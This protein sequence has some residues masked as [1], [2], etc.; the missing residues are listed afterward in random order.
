MTICFKVYCSSNQ[1]TKCYQLFMLMVCSYF[2]LT[3]HLIL[4]FRTEI[5]F[6]S[7]Q[8]N[9]LLDPTPHFPLSHYTQYTVHCLS[10]GF[11]WTMRKTYRGKSPWYASTGLYSDLLLLWLRCGNYQHDDEAETS[12]CC[13]CCWV[14]V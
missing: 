3:F 4:S 2:S 10:S 1:N 8:I 11:S 14:S 13:Y 12:T 6:K 9:I 5:Y 7:F